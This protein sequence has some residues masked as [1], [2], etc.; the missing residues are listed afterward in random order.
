MWQTWE[1]Q[2]Y[3]NSD[4]IILCAANICSLNAGGEMG[5]EAANKLRVCLANS[6]VFVIPADDKKLNASAVLI[7]QRLQL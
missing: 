2:W 5:I 6:F 7:Q 3:R 1:L 4:V